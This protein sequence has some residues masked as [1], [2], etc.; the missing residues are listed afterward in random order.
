MVV[1][2][3]SRGESQPSL[4]RRSLSDTSLAS[5]SGDGS[6]RSISFRSKINSRSFRKSDDGTYAQSPSKRNNGAGPP[7]DPF[8]LSPFPF[9]RPSSVVPSHRCPP[10]FPWTRSLALSR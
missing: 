10:P 4:L 8:S 5:P 3:G 9:P 6:L 1:E 2:D 7:S